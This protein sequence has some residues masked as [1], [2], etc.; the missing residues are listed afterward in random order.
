MTTYY[1]NL[2]NYCLSASTLLH[3]FFFLVLF[4]RLTQ[5]VSLRLL[6]FIRLSLLRRSILS[7]LLFLTIALTL[8]IFLIMLRTVYFKSVFLPRISLFIHL[9]I[10]FLH[11]F[12]GNR[13]KCLLHILCS[14]GTSFKEV[15]LLS[16]SVLLDL[17]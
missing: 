9:F 2:I 14:F 3:L 4:L 11:Q 10:L 16:L 13:D 6:A 12:F 5:F 8:S 7:L 17:L 1:Y 15:H